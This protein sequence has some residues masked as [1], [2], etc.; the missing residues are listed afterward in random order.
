MIF[1][2]YYAEGSSE[3]IRLKGAAESLTDREFAE[4]Q[5]IEVALE[6]TDIPIPENIRRLFMKQ[7]GSLLSEREES[8]TRMRKRY[9]KYCEKH[10]N[11]RDSD[12]DH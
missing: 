8:L 5:F 3:R 1:S 9:T 11:Q 6:G 7:G 2:K 10:K 4:A 12:S